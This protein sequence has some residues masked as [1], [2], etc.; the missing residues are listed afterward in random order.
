MFGIHCYWREHIVWVI[1]ILMTS[2]YMC[3]NSD[4]YYDIT[5]YEQRNCWREGHLDWWL[6]YCHCIA[7]YMKFYSRY[8]SIT[9]ETFIHLLK[10]FLF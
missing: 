6:L 4:D 5:C 8:S 1:V 3:I 10:V 9:S 2:V 7:F